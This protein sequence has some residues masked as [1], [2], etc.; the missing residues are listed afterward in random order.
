MPAGGG[1]TQT[2]VNRSA[3]ARTQFAELVTA[4]T[5]LATLLLLAPL[6]ALMPNAVLAAVVVVYSIAA[7]QAGGVPRDRARPARPSSTGRPPRAS[8]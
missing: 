4:A 6:I 8:A 1:T 2:A 3:G 5:A 7:D